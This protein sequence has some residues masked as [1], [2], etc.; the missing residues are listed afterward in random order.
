M[1]TMIGM[2][3][4]LSSGTVS[5]RCCSLQYRDNNKRPQAV[6]FHKF[7]TFFKIRTSKSG[8]RL[9]CFVHFDFE[10]LFAL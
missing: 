6:I 10:V 7:V 3:V 4:L 1:L 8:L 2:A 5:R 9:V